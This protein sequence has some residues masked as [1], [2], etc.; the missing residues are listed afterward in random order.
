MTQRFTH[1][2]IMDPEALTAY[3]PNTRRVYASAWQTFLSWSEQQTRPH[4]LPVSST[5]LLEYLQQLAT[6]GRSWSTLQT[7]RAVIVKAHRRA[8]LPNPA[9]NEPFRE[10]MRALARSVGK[11]Q[12]QVQALTE[13]AAAAINATALI[14]QTA[15]GG[16]PETPARTAKRAAADVAIVSLM[17]DA[18]LRSAEA[19]DLRWHD[20]ELHPDGTGR[21]LVR[22]SKTDQTGLGTLLFLSR[23]CVL[24]LAKHR[25]HQGSPPDDTLI[26]G[27]CA[28]QIRRRI[29]NA[30]AKAG[31][32]GNFGAHSPRIGMAVDLAQTGTGLPEIQQAGRWKSPDMPAHYIRGITAGH[33]AVARYHSARNT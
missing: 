7:H 3:A 16:K 25:D 33:G 31:L 17:R 8:G 6:H 9:D 20:L 24:A 11:H 12:N 23:S 22:H 27:L 26:F 1:E 5:D 15:P 4:Q 21:I 10:A 30:T 29:K 32:P 2:T 18:L 19:A 28:A 14:P 13:S